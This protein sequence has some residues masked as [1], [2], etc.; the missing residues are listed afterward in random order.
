MMDSIFEFEKNIVTNLKLLCGDVSGKSFLIALSG[1]ADS[2]SLLTALN[3]LSKA[4]SFSVYACHVNHMIRGEEADSDAVFCAD[5]CK[6][7]NIRLFTYKEDIPKLADLSRKSIELCARE[8]RYSVFDT[9]CKENRIDFVCTA[10]NANDNAETVLF[11]II[12]GASVSG[13]RGI[14]KR[15]DKILRP[16]LNKTREEIL[17][18]LNE[19]RIGYV[20]D[21]TNSDVKY[22]RNYVRNVL[23][24]SA[25]NI[26]PDV[27]SALNRFSS[28][29]TNDCDYLDNLAF[30]N[31]KNKNKKLALYPNALKTRMIKFMF[32]ELS[33]KELSFQNIVDICNCLDKDF[34]AKCYLPDNI[35][36][37]C[38]YGDLVFI[39]DACPA[40]RIQKQNLLYGDKIPYDG[41]IIKTE[42]ST[43]AKNNAFC[44]ALP[45]DT[46]IDTLT[47]R[48]REEGDKFMVRGINRTIKKCL[49]DKKI[50]SHLRD[51]IPIICDDKGI[52]F[53]P[54]IG[55]AD[56]AYTRGECLQISVFFDERFG[57]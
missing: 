49:I 7:L 4:H 23:L 16:I 37:I 41:I 55:V 53:V 48:S 51:I 21:S 19:N 25:I 8:Y 31:L 54:F 47:V 11:N 45:I 9:V 14:P 1:G 29:A 5:I 22:T 36:A 18:Y 57:F 39:K 24:P 27:I 34:E 3:N 20:V 6:K 46:D 28:M 10:H 40:S 43:D 15:R 12:R 32:A 26:N 35:T 33:E 56:R 42:V 13:A 2:V 17:S 44:G 38:N 52:V 50:P 30:E